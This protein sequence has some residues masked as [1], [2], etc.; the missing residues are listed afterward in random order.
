MFNFRHP[1]GRN[2]PFKL[3]L[4]I[5]TADKAQK[6]ELQHSRR[7]L[8]LTLANF[9]NLIPTSCIS[10]RT[11]LLQDIVADK[12]SYFICLKNKSVS[13]KIKPGTSNDS[14]K[15]EF[16]GNL[17]EALKKLSGTNLMNSV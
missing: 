11:D 4:S 7:E 2:Y 17:A 8:V 16:I 5:K 12:K 13:A 1:Y 14:K 15:L 3:K 6:S 9:I 10:N